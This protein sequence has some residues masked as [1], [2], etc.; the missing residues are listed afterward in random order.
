VMQVAW[1]GSL[2]GSGSGAAIFL[3]VKGAALTPPLLS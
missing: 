2:F 1:R 3:E